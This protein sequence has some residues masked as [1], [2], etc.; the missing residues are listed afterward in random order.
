VAVVAADDA[1]RALSVMRALPEGAEAARIGEVRADPP[2]MVFIRTAFGGTRVVDM[3][4][5]DPLPRIC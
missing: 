2:A 1:E 4:I 3:L 5:G